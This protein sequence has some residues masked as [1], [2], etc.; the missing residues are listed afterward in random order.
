MYERGTQLE[1][2]SSCYPHISY[3]LDVG[4]TYEFAPFFMESRDIVR[5]ETSEKKNL[6]YF[7]EFLVYKSINPFIY[8]E[9]CR[10]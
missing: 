7:L 3:I 5:W 2:L 1:F 4:G 10:F 9:M 6:P 8:I